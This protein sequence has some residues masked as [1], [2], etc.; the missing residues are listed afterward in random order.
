MVYLSEKNWSFKY[1]I[2]KKKLESIGVNTKS[3]INFFKKM[4]DKN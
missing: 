4:Y 3:E 2:V 1:F